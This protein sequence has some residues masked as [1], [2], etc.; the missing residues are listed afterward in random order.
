MKINN[1][2]IHE[3]RNALSHNRN[4]QTKFKQILKNFMHKQLSSFNEN[5]KSS[6]IHF[7]AQNLR[8]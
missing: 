5:K 6:F 7:L 8:K 3:L 4:P 1:I 2:M